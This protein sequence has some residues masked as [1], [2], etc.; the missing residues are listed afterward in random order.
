MNNV[1]LQT[2]KNVFM[3]LIAYLHDKLV[4]ISAT[5]TVKNKHQNLI[6]TEPKIFSPGEVKNPPDTV[7]NPGEISD[8]TEFTAGS[9][10]DSRGIISYKIIGQRGPNSN[11]LYLIV[12]WKVKL[13]GENS[14]NINVR[15]YEEF[16]SLDKSLLKEL[17]RGNT[18]S[19][20]PNKTVKYHDN[21]HDFIVTGIID[22]KSNAKIK[23]TLSQ[24]FQN[25]EIT[26]PIEVP[27]T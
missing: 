26:E 4:K 22:N 19:T 24:N 18:G 1:E 16:P 13:S 17:H 12:T 2:T 7:I 23:I 6:L 3:V 14:I 9:G 21:R 10:Q 15:E 27:D 8:S 25:T 5:L 11:P 20:C